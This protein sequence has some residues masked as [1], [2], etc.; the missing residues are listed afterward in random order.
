MSQNKNITVPIKGMHCRSCELLIEDSLKEIPEI[1]STELNYHTGEAKIFYNGSAPDMKAISRAINDAGYKIGN[2]ETL[3]FINRHKEE[4]KNLGIAFLIIAVIYLVLKSFGLTSINLSPDINN[5]SI[6][7]IIVIGLVAGFSTC[8][9]LV[10]GLSLGL[11]T[12]F[13]ER[14]PNATPAEKFRPHLFFVAGRILS[15]ALLGGFLGMIGAVFQLSAIASSAITIIVG[16]VMI[17]MGLQLINIFPRL[18]KFKLT[19][20]KGVSRAF[21]FGQKKKEYSHGQAM[22]MGAF[23]FFLPCGFTQAMQLYAVSTGS[24]L[25]GALTMGL[26]ALGTA[27]GLLSIGGVT[28]LVRGQFKERFFKVAGLAVI[29]FGLFNLNNGYTLASLNFSNLNSAISANQKEIVSDPNVTLED[30]VQIVKMVE[31]NQ[32]Y[33][34]NSFSIKKG[35]PVKWI[36]DAQAPYSCAST[37]VVPK[38]GI[39]KSLVAGENTIEFTPSETGKIPFSCSMGMYTGVF[40]V[41]DDSVVNSDASINNNASQTANGASLATVNSAA[42]SSCG[43]SGGGCGCGGGN[44][45]KLNKDLTNTIAQTEGDVQVINSTYTAGKYLSPN[46]FKVKLGTKVRFTIDVKDDGTGC[47]YA[48]MIPGLDNNASEIKAGQPIVMEFTPTTKGTFDITCSMNMIRFGSITV[49]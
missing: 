47:G 8:M 6:G 40:N 24:F 12:K 41:Y 48:M 31:G 18:S 36:I 23:T 15:Y 39:Q 21:G 33:S 37:I 29:F 34:P 1:K 27:P 11:S 10:G 25:S 7:L 38:L 13:I 28:S 43:A 32:G 2:E 5:P 3:P 42:A 35:I 22:I 17:L 16:L 30:G 19:L 26:F 44:A 49:E 45:T 14:H 9:A 20:P 46:S 4:Y